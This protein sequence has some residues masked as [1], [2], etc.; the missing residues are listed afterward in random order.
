MNSPNASAPRHELKM[1]EDDFF[2]SKTDLKS[3]ITY[4]NQ[5]FCKISG[6]VES[7]LLGINHDIVRCSIM[8]H[9]IYNLLWEHLR[10]E[11]E[12]FGYIANQNKDGSYYWAFLNVAPCYEN[13]KLTG[14]F[15]VQR[16][17]S[18]QAL[19][20]IKPLYQTMCKIEKDAEPAQLLPLSSSVLWQAIT[21][22]YQSYAEF[23]LSL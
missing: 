6:Y 4:I 15:A 13:N 12:F 20:T 17:P 11:E 2:V 5:G 22:E 18:K 21:K 3:K 16:M 9:G 14:Y 8:P 1:K 7:E 19:E 23:V 10:A